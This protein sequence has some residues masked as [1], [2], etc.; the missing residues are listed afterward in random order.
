LSRIGLAYVPKM[1][2]ALVG[3]ASQSHFLAGH[4]GESR[5]G[6]EVSFG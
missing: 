4:D 5:D 3:F 2:A 6:G 1:P